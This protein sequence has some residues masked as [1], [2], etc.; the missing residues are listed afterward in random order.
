MIQDVPIQ[1]RQMG[2]I[3]L[4]DGGEISTTSTWMSAGVAQ[5]GRADLAFLNVKPMPSPPTRMR[6]S[7]SVLS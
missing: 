5:I 7:P 4:D 2:A 3:P 6:N 1:G